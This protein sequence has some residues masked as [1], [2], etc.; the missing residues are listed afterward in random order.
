MYF[1]YRN[2]KKV[3]KQ[4]YIDARRSLV[5]STLFLQTSYLKLSI[6]SMNNYIALYMR[7]CGLYK[8]LSKII[9]ILIIK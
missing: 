3:A 1:L 4:C 8:R 2:T 7:Q 5:K 6:S 9:L